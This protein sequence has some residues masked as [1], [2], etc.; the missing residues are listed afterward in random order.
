MIRQIVSYLQ[1]S[2]NY[3]G[4]QVQPLVIEGEAE[5]IINGLLFSIFGSKLNH[6]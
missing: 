1:I 6:V 2:H 3:T 5:Y 4:S